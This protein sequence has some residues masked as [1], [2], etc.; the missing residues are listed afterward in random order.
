MFD[1]D[2]FAE[3]D[4][5]SDSCFDEFHQGEEGIQSVNRMERIKNIFS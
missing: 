4:E 5:F 3:A 2:E 1:E